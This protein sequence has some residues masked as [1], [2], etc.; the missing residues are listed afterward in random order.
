MNSIKLYNGIEIPE[1]GYGTWKTP[2]NEITI[3]SVKTAIE[4]G[5]THIDCASVYGNEKEVGEGIKLSGVNRS[6]LFITGKLWNDVRGYHETIDAFNKTLTDLG[7]EYLDLYLI[8]W[9]VPIKYKD[10]YIE[11]NIET[12]KAM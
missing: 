9:P 5:Y 2:N 6:D 4:A 1:V 10:N 8:H 7:V 12:W 11:K 3:N